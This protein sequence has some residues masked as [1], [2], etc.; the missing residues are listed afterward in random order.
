MWK[1]QI[2]P[3]AFIILSRHRNENTENTLSNLADIKWII[4]IE[5]DLLLQFFLFL[6][7]QYFYLSTN[8]MG[9]D[10]TFRFF[11]ISFHNHHFTYGVLTTKYICKLVITTPNFINNN[12]KIH[13]YY[14]YT[15]TVDKFSQSA[16]TVVLLFPVRFLTGP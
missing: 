2:A 7:S 3:L 14:T 6:I 9:P 8:L 4:E 15:Y 16:E 10:K 1:V 5:L 13:T 12:K 11:M